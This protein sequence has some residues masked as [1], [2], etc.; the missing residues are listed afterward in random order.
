MPAL[1]G[2]TGS[3][4]WCGEPILRPDGRTNWRARWHPGCVT[5]YRLAVFSS[6]QRRAVWARDRGV[7]VT[8]GVRVQTWDADH[9]KPLWSIPP[10]LSLFD[11]SKWFGLENLQT[12]CGPHHKAK[13]RMEASVRALWARWTHETIGPTT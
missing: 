4:R 5:A 7:C 3:C 11:R 10:D 6:D 12:L 8:C 13:S 1:L 9:I 2:A